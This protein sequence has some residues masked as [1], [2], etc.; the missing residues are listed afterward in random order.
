MNQTR[1]NPLLVK[2]EILADL[3]MTY[4][5]FIVNAHREYYIADQ[6]KRSALSIGE[7]IAEAQRISSHRSFLDKLRRALSECQELGYWMRR[8]R[9]ADYHH[10]DL[11]S[12]LLG[13]LAEVSKLLMAS[14]KTIDAK[15]NG[16]PKK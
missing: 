8:V 14:C 5:R 13:V 16:N 4:S 6:V 7:F 11:H 12:E 1:P 2:A 9:N 10:E 15:I 3:G